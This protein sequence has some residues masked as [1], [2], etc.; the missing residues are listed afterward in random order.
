MNKEDSHDIRTFVIL[1]SRLSACREPG[2]V[3]VI[4]TEHFGK[5]EEHKINGR[6]LPFT[7]FYDR[8]KGFPMVTLIRSPELEQYRYL[9]S[10]TNIS[11]KMFLMVTEV[12]WRHFETEGITK[13]GRYNA[14]IGRK[15]TVRKQI[16]QKIMK[17]FYRKSVPGKTVPFITVLPKTVQ[18]GFRIL[19]RNLREIC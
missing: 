14:E 11:F 10:I 6:V 19:S 15:P 12:C 9:E 7:E 3:E 17:A 13:Q 1:N 4:G 18:R 16:Y 8:L 5:A 2:D